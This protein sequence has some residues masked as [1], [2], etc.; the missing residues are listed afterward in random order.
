MSRWK[1]LIA[2]IIC[3]A[4]LIL[5][6]SFADAAVAP[7]PNAITTLP[8]Q[9]T[10][11]DPPGPITTLPPASITTLPPGTSCS[12]LAHTGLHGALTLTNA[13]NGQ[14]ICVGIHS[15]LIVLL[16]SP[17]FTAPMWSLPRATP[18][19]FLAPAPMTF[20]VPRGER[21]EVFRAIQKGIVQIR[22]Q[23]HLCPIASATESCEV[24]QGW[25]VT[26]VIVP[27]YARTS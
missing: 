20:L 6:A 19:G 15:E 3:L 4:S 16:R 2:G 11:S 24:L 1:A 25:H 17:N 8:P 22:A 9:P 21:G 13:N 10:T 18:A 27:T 5:A 14:E 7:G 26:L 12:H 23:R